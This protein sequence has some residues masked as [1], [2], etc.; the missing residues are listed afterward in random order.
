MCIHPYC[1]LPQH[2]YTTLSIH[3]NQTTCTKYIFRSSYR[4]SWTMI[5]LAARI[6]QLR[7]DADRL[8]ICTVSNT[9]QA[10]YWK[11]FNLFEVTHLRAPNAN[12]LTSC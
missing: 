12:R 4:A 9:L 6:V 1:A 11:R 10:R 2:T 5:L 8:T 7:V 3:A